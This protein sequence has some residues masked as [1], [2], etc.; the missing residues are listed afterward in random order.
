MVA[1]NGAGLASPDS[2]AAQFTGTTAWTSWKLGCTFPGNQ[3]VTQGRSATWAQS[4]AD[5]TAAA[6]PWNG[7][8]EPGQSVAIGF[9]GS[10][11]GTN[12]DSSAFTVDGRACA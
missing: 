1:R 2:P 4:G 10:C 9:N 3:K 5:V 12:P 11:T 7:S 6:M 8:V